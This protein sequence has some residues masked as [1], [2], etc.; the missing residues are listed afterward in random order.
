[1]HEKVTTLKLSCNQEKKEYL[2]FSMKRDLWR[3]V[4]FEAKD[5]RIQGLVSANTFKLINKKRKK[6]GITWNE[7]IA[8]CVIKFLE[9]EK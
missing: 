3:L 4:M 6:M 9:D 1:L 7:L 2:L 5:E 8:Y